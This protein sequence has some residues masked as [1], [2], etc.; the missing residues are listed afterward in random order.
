MAA[1]NRPDVLD[2]ALLRPGRFDRQVTLQQPDIEGRKAILTVHMRDQ[3][4]KNLGE[5][6]DVD[7]LGKQTAGFSGADLANLINE[8]AIL[9]AR[10]NKKKI[11]M[12]EFEEA[13]D[14]VLA[15]PARRSRIISE[16]VRT[17]TAYHE[18]GH[19]LVAKLLPNADPVHKIS[20]VSRGQ[21]GG[22]TRF[23]PDEDRDYY[24][25]AQFEDMIATLLA[26]FSTEKIVFKDVST[27]AS[28]DI[29]RATTI[30]RQ[31]VTKYGMSDR[32]GPMAIGGK[33]EA[34]FLGRE[35]SS[36]HDYS[37]QVATEVDREIERIIDQ[38]FKRASKLIEE[39]RPI[40]DEAAKILVEKETLDADTFNTFFNGVESVKIKNEQQQAKKKKAL[41]DSQSL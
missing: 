35:I 27:G 24:S 9:T 12:D 6:V 36:R 37:E 29:Q 4:S 15:G 20:I 31:M 25:K 7:V 34:V 2:P 3:I 38:Q 39:H 30:A 19:A 14:R 5:D 17:M 21:M 16:K 10:R 13:I 23:L 28:S 22:Y 32:F 8:A 40:M 33:E 11:G 41:E 26:G 1:T 18:I